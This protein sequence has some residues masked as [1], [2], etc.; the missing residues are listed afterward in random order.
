MN[1]TPFPIQQLAELIR[2]CI[3]S[4]APVEID[5]LGIFRAGPDG[6]IRF[7]PNPRPKV[8]IS[9]ASEDSAAAVRL[10]N[11]LEDQ[12][13]EPWLDRKRLL[14]GQNWPRALERAIA[15]AD[16]FV[17]CFSTRSTGKRGQFQAEVRYALDCARTLPPDS[18]FVVPVR[19]EPCHV[20]RII[21]EQ[22]HYVDLFPD[23]D[24]GMIRLL[25]ALK[26]HWRLR[27]GDRR[28]PA[29]DLAA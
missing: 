6:A 12:G 8:F 13:F 2:D 11:F 9:Y 1:T 7:T 5:G 26:A 4:G 14:A 24:E 18:A 25:V 16:F 17:P 28:P 15:R 22:L 19:L 23:W 27:Q 10:Y 21:Q 3:A 20:P 29:S